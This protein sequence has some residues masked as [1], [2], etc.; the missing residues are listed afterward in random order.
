[1]AGRASIAW[2]AGVCA[3]ILIMVPSGVSAT[4]TPSLPRVHPGLLLPVW[5]MSTDAYLSVIRVV[6]RVLVTFNGISLEGRDAATGRLIWRQ[7]L[8]LFDDARELDF[9]VNGDLVTLSYWR[10]RDDGDTRNQNV[11]TFNARTGALLWEF[12]SSLTKDPPEDGFSLLGAG[13]GRIVIATGLGGEA[14]SALDARDGSV[15]W[16]VPVPRNCSFDSGGADGALAAV[17]LRCSRAVRL[18]VLSLSAGRVLWDTA[19]RGLKDTRTEVIGDVVSVVGTDRGLMFDSRG[20]VLADY[21]TNNPYDT[22]V[23]VGSRI[24]ALVHPDETSYYNRVELI[25]S[26]TGARR[27]WLAE[28]PPR[29]MAVDGEIYLEAGVPGFP[30]ARVLSR[31]GTG[32]ETVPIGALPGR[33]TWG[34]SSLLVAGAGMLFV[35]GSPADSES[36][37]VVAYRPDPLPSSAE[38]GLVVRGGVPA[39][40]WPDACALVTPAR[41]AALVP[42]GRYTARPQHAAPELGL[43]R[44]IGCDLESANGSDPPVTL[45]V[46]WVCATA[47]DAAFRMGFVRRTGLDHPAALRGIGD[48]AFTRQATEDLVVVRVGEMIIRLD[49]PGDPALARRLAAEVAD[50]I[51]GV[52]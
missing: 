39:A 30:L 35:D 20:H 51:R 25:D 13:S 10:V 31:V 47:E 38:R 46:L 24:V 22:W 36:T 33:W 26:V 42:G 21:P 28:E 1:M 40:R 27:S 37:V 8:T 17:V 6:G 9:V 11:V 48:E 12:A 50:A 2:L 29:L 41:L 16:R 43:D 19:V 15:V 45:S 23:E 7:T 34:G 49:A 44:P 18:R 4:Q 52:S 14:V 32:A 3:A 5:K